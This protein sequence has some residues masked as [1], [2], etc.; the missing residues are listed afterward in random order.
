MMKRFIQERGKI[1][2]RINSNRR[3]DRYLHLYITAI[4]AINMVLI[5][6][7]MIA[8]TARMSL[9]GVGII[10]SMPIALYILPLV[11]F[12]PLMIRDYYQSRTAA[13]S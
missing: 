13:S 9:S 12:L 3:V 6:Y 11:I 7:T 1:R 2:R 8:V 10:D 5:L 4:I